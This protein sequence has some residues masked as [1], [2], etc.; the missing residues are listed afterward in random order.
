M[1]GTEREATV[2]V[3]REH[4]DAFASPGRALPQIRAKSA[5]LALCMRYRASGASADMPV[6]PSGR[7]RPRDL[8]GRSR[9]ARCPVRSQLESERQRAL[10]DRESPQQGVNPVANQWELHPAMNAVMPTAVAVAACLACLLTGALAVEF[11]N[12]GK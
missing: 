10:R 5:S 12:C 9:R 4:L 8:R 6:S 3:R 1:A 11:K 2:F 7:V